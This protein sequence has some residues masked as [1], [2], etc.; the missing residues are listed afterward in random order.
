MGGVCRLLS[1]GNA[2]DGPACTDN[3]QVVSIQFEHNSKL[4]WSAEQAYQASKFDSRSKLY[5]DI[6]KAD[7]GKRES[8]WDYGMRVWR[9]GQEKPPVDSWPNEKVRSMLLVNISKFQSR[10][11][12]RD[13]LSATGDQAIEGAPSTWHWQTYNGQIMTLIREI[14]RSGCLESLKVKV[15]EM[16]QSEIV[17]MLQPSV[18]TTEG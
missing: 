17:A 4:W 16:D 12:M 8:D 3:F 5:S 7:P 6:L 18:G 1:D 11:K 14:I 15:C 10:Q 13:E 2:I 9:M